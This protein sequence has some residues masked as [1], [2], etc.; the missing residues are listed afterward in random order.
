MATFIFRNDAT[1][2]TV[3]RRLPLSLFDETARKA[4]REFRRDGFSLLR[5]DLDEV[6]PLVR[7]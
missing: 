1:G 6:E 2:E 3:R 4:L 7:L 5:I